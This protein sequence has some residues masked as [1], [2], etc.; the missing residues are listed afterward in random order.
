MSINGL[1]EEGEAF[2]RLHEETARTRVDVLVIGG[3]QAGLSVGYHLKQLGLL[4]LKRERTSS[5][6]PMRRST[7]G[8][9]RL[10]NKN[11]R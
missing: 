6:R 3:G 4:R 1:I 9:I 2:S 11:E 7:P 5:A 10:L 8:G